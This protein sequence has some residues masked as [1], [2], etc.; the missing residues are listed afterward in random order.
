MRALCARAAE[1]GCVMHGAIRSGAAVCRSIDRLYIV[2]R[3]TA[4]ALDDDRWSMLV[5][6]HDERWHVTVTRDRTA[7]SP[8]EKPPVM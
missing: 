7:G 6:V 8:I 3:C 2:A 5:E 4:G 1:A